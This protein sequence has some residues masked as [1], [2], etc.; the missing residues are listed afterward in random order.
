MQDERIRVPLS[1]ELYA[2]RD[3]CDQIRVGRAVAAEFGVDAVN[4]VGIGGGV[5]HGDY[6][7]S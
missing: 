4:E 3:A 2:F 7:R 6:S 5:G 1:G